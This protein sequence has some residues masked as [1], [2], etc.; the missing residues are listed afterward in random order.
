MVVDDFL[1]KITI[2]VSELFNEA[3]PLGKKFALPL[4]KKHEDDHISGE[5]HLKV[6]FI[7]GDNKK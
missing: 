6:D 3:H 2:P 5:I 7:A 4:L 1:G